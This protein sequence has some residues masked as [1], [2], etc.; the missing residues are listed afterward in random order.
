MIERDL[1][2]QPEDQN[3]NGN[4]SKVSPLVIQNAVR[5]LD[6]YIIRHR[7][8]VGD[9]TLRGRQLTVFEDMRDLL[10]NGDTEGYVKLPT[11][12][13]KTVLFTEFIEATRLKT[14]IV[15]PTTILVNQTGQ[16]IQEFAQD[17]DFGK[18]YG[19]SKR[20]GRQVTITTYQSLLR[21]LQ[22][23]K[24]SPEEYEL[25][26]LD[27]VHQ[28]LTRK[29]AEAVGKFTNSIKLGFTATPKFSEDKN[30]QQLLNTEIHSMSIR[31]AVEED[32]L[33]SFSVFI[34]Q[35]DI[36]LS[37]VSIASSGEYNEEEL[38]KAVDV[39]N[40]NK[41]AV[42]LY[43]KL[44]EGQ[45]AVVYCSGIR[46][47]GNMAGLFREAGVSAGFISGKN[48]EK[49]KQEILRQFK[50]GEIKVLCNSDI[51]IQ[52]FDEPRASVCV[53]LRPTLSLVLAEQRGGRVLRKDQN[54][55]QKH[56]YIVDFFDKTENGRNILVSFAQVAE[57]VSIIAGT[58]G[59]GNGGGGG[60]HIIYPPTGEEIII[61]ELKVITNAEEV[62]RIIREMENRKFERAPE[63]WMNAHAL[64]GLFR[65]SHETIKKESEKYREM[66][67]DWFKRFLPK[68]RE[69]T[70]F[71]SPELVK[72]IG[73]EF[74]G[75]RYA[76]EGWMNDNSILKTFGVGPDI[77]DRSVA[78]YRNSNP[79]WFGKYL[80]LNNRLIEFY[81][82]ELISVL[83]NKVRG[84]SSSSEGWIH[85]GNLSKFVK[86]GLV[87][88]GK[89][90]DEYRKS[91]PEW[92]KQL[93]GKGGKIRE[94][95]SPE[96]V[97]LVTQ[98]AKESLKPPAGWM[99]RNYIVRLVGR[100]GQY[101]GKKISQYRTGHPE[102]FSKYFV[103][104][105][106]K[107]I[108][109]CSSEFVN[110][111]KEE[112]KQLEPPEGWIN[113]NNF[114]TLFRKNSEPIKKATMKYRQGHP[115]WFKQYASKNGL[116]VEFYSPE[117]VELMK[118]D[119]EVK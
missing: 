116:I 8:R 100:N 49:E 107:P 64:T 72:I 109:F 91:H 84:F 81:S 62:L 16:R 118:K 34:A 36:D 93:V 101:I 92:F 89:I 14:L 51:L 63:G 28:S 90:I 83:E 112:L 86:K 104:K 23:G 53:N 3:T 21:N 22:N 111:I 102:W 52:G 6:R 105:G 113:T 82:P 56:A 114:S 70:E 1:G 67:P 7:E 59:G 85:I 41:G 37:S 43:K 44:F 48:T 12:V 76:P 31:E 40:R 15:V 20:F 2:Y 87:E 94:F 10:Q 42:D 95:Y 30:V 47:A 33:C 5:S 13:G 88:C 110:V 66:Y 54:N 25:L 80:A 65:K 24:M 73:K 26:V 17:L 99:D 57:S 55:P 77:I 50:S 4:E 9:R 71:Y 32:L 46:H 27:E 78:M 38:Q 117:L 18:V 35:S 79:E 115:E 97:N 74:S 61:P 103:G 60:G 68:K 19:A 39:Y 119:L 96:L 108:E 106:G 98:R 11:G 69:V 45:T 58:S 75:L 29:R